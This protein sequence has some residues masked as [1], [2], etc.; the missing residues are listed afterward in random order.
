MSTDGTVR[1]ELRW[2]DA[3]GRGLEHCLL[4]LDGAGLVLEG[5]VAGTRDGFYGAHYIV[6]ADAQ[7]RT[8][9]VRLRYVGGPDLHLTADENARWHDVLR[10]APLPDLDG[11]LD[12]DIGITPATNTLPIRRLGLAPGETRAVRAAYVPL[13]SEIE[14]AFRPRPAEQRYTRLADRVWRYDG[15]F[16]DFTAELTVD[17]LGLVL[18]Y[19]AL[20]RRLGTADGPGSAGPPA[21]PAGRPADEAGT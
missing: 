10:G 12:V 19:P 9:E 11:C 5:A 17:D 13:P 14:G 20:F 6:R 1:R 16:R 8:R 2:T 15:L 7:G 4:T 18:D 3:G 21:A